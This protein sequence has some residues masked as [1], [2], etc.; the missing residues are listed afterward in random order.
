[1]L[2]CDPKV[3]PSAEKILAKPFL[4]NAVKKNKRVPDTLEERFMKSTENFDEAYKDSEEF[5]SEWKNITDSLEEVHRK[6]TI[7]SLSGS[8][9]G[10]AGGITAIVGAVLA[11][12]TLGASLIVTGVGIG[13][14][15]AGGITGA[16]SNITDTVKQKSLRESLENLDKKYKE[17]DALIFNSPKTL[18]FLREITKF[19]DFVSYSTLDNIQISWRVGRSSVVCAAEVLNLLANIGRIGTQAA[20]FGKAAV[21]ASGVLSGILLAADIAFIAKD[22]REIHQMRQGNIDDPT[23][24]KSST[25]NS[26]IQMR[27]MHTDLCNV[28]QG[29][30]ETRESILKKRQSRKLE[31]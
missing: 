30:K 23:K 25:L 5:L 22:S 3:R 20:K 12:F 21:A 24:V 26:I 10:A 28:L 19:Q 31:I 27:K 8:V 16:A 9:I 17:G 7:G 18:R 15:V 29:I 6:C 4:K 13:V 11:P 2:S 14:S 1:M